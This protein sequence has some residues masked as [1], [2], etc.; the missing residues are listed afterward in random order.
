[1]DSIEFNT[2]GNPAMDWNLVYAIEREIC[3]DGSLDHHP[4][5]VIN[6]SEISEPC[7]ETMCNSRKYPYLPHRRE[8]S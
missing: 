6:S 7:E 2:G 3:S 8:F 5:E 1:M 4:V